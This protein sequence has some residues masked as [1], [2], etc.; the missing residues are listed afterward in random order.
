[1]I[2]GVRMRKLAELTTADERTLAFGGMGLIMGGQ[3][4]P[5]DAA[6]L[7]QRWIE[8]AD[9]I[10][11]VPEATTESFERLRN[12]HCYGV[13]CYDAFTVASDLRWIVLEQALRQ[14]FIEF[15]EG[16]IPL[17]GKDG[18]EE[19]FV[20]DDFQ[21]IS[22]A[23]RPRGSHVKGWWLKPHIGSVRM[24]MPLTLDPL[25]RWARR[26]RLLEGQRNR[27]L[28]ESVF[29][30]MRNRFAH[31]TGHSVNMPNYSARAICDLAEIINRLWGEATPGG[32]LYPA[33][34]S[35]E[36]LAVGWS[37]VPLGVATI[38][39]HADQLARHTDD[40]PGWRYV[41]VRGVWGDENLSEFDARYDMT[42]YP[43]DLLWGPGDR[44]GAVAWI[45]ATAPC[46]DDVGY[47]D[48]VFAIRRDSGKV[49]L[50]CRPEI[51]LGLPAAHRAGTWHIVRADFPDDAFSHVRHLALGD[52]CPT[53]PDGSGRC[54]AE[55]IATGSWPEV[56]AIVH[57]EWP[58]LEP[59]E[60][61]DVCVPR[62][63]PFPD[64]VGYD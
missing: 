23:F 57:R 41:V 25:L 8:A 50:P 16:A 18:A 31:G 1:M 53:A 40:G 39:M 62:R 19:A 6:E 61:Q 59:L 42:T 4:R 54:A 55:D 49:F 52:P 3:L 30:Y 24:R 64:A 20:A 63:T 34:L 46:G 7:Q 43:T 21:V 14:R 2:R 37:K 60:R 22:T 36:V 58:S 29:G 33:P 17:V 27:R 15:Y 32:R 12:L 5:E 51:L 45:A 48:R 26:E 28:E 10:D 38:V 47:L 56:S 35:R 13:L 11:V 9:L 44:D